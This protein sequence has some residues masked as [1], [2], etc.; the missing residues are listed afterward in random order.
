ML[1][2]VANLFELNKCLKII[3]ITK[4]LR[5]PLE[6]NPNPGNFKD[7]NPNPKANPNLENL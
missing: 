4:T 3:N 6:P 1:V 5:F 2:C 7:P